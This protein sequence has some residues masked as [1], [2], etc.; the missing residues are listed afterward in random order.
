MT[1]TVRVL[2]SI[3]SDILGRFNNMFKGLPRPP[4]YRQVMEALRAKADVFARAADRNRPS[5]L[6]GMRLSRAAAMT[7]DVDLA[8][9]RSISIAVE[10]STPPMLDVLRAVGSDVPSDPNR[11]RPLRLDRLRQFRQFSPRH[12]HRPSWRRRRNGRADETRRACRRLRRTAALHGLPPQRPDPLRGPLRTGRERQRARAGAVR[13]PQLI[14]SMRRPKDAVGSAKSRKDL[15]Q[16]GELILAFDQS[17]RGSC[18]RA[19]VARSVGAGAALAARPATRRRGAG[20][21]GA[22]RARA[23][24]GRRRRFGPG[25]TTPIHLPSQSSCFYRLS[26]LR[27][28]DDRLAPASL[29]RRSR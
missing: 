3:R 1:Q 9:F 6:L 28:K 29:R 21:R 27:S 25:L 26:R 17:G 13:G 20:R 24:F 2:Y 23:A 12:S 18:N 7:G 10:D 22:R 8:Q 14:V 16:S 15:A 5:G 4:G 19:G 11:N